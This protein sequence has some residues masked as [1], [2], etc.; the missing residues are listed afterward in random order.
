MSSTQK[1]KTSG[2]TVPLGLAVSKEGALRL[3]TTRTLADSD[4]LPRGVP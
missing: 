1:R 4:R 3:E 2:T